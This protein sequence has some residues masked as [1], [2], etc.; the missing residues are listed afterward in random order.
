MDIVTACD[1]AKINSY[2]QNLTGEGREWMSEMIGFMRENFPAA[3]EGM[4]KGAPA[5]TFKEH[6]VGFA[7]TESCFIFT[8]SDGECIENLTMLMPDAVLIEDGIMVGF[9]DAGIVWTLLDA[10]QDIAR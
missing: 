8:T 4:C 3:T 10:I 1:R 5:Y 9:E 7:A 6:S 2:V